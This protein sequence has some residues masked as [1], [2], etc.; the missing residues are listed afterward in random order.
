M[1]GGGDGVG[2]GEVVVLLKH[3]VLG[4]VDE[5]EHHRREGGDRHYWYDY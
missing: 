5:L 3:V 2:S 1:D 4:L